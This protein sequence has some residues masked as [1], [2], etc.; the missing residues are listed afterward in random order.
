MKSTHF[1]NK[2]LPIFYQYKL[3]F[4]NQTVDCQKKK[5]KKNQSVRPVLW[6]D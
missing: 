2:N 3:S 1:P 5:E 6:Q 4:K